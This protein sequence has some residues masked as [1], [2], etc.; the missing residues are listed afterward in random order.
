MISIDLLNFAYPY[1]AG[2]LTP[3]PN[4]KTQDSC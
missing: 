1:H 3:S 4:Q 2:P